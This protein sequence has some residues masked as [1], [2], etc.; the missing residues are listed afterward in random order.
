[1]GAIIFNNHDEFPDCMV[2]IETTSVQPDRGGILQIAAVKFNLKENT[3][4]PDFFD[5]C[6]TIPRH[7]SWSEDTRNFWLNQK[8]EVLRDILMRAEPWQDVIKKFMDYAYPLNSLRFW[9]KPSHFDYNF[10]SSYF[11]DLN[12]GP[13]PF[14]YREAN[15]MNSFLRG[16]YWE[17][18]GKVPEVNLP[19]EGEVHNALYDTLHQVKVLLHHVHELKKESQEII[20]QIKD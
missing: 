3:V 12:E 7:R 18:G 14:H 17:N 16:L 9:S 20:E 2:D 6:L 11:Y 1:M 15:D 10:I 5:M 13:M 4:S 19:F 8:E